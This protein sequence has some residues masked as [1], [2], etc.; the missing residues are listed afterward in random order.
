MHLLMI[1]LEQAKRKYQKYVTVAAT[2]PAYFW[3]PIAGTFSAPVVAG[4]YGRRAA[5]KK[6][7]I[8]SKIII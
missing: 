3:V 6:K 4:I 5:L 7:E 2:T 8:D 1:K